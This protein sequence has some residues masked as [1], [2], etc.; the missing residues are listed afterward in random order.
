L[1]REVLQGEIE[2]ALAGRPS[3]AKIRV[4]VQRLLDRA[5]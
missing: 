2:E 4:L 3:K 5:A 1:L